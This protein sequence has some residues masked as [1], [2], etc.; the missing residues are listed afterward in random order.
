[1]K[2]RTHFAHRIEMWTNDGEKVIEHIAGVE[3]LRRGD[4][5]LQGRLRTLARNFHHPAPRG[6]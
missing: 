6:T 4:C 2:T 1:M 3:G 5:D